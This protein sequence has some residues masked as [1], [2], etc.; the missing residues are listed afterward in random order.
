MQAP[1]FP[2]SPR[3]TWEP[4]RNTPKVSF[5]VPAWNGRQ[6][7]EAFVSAYRALSYP[8]KELVL[9]VGGRDEGFEI[10]K[11]LSSA[12]VLVLEQLPGE[13]KQRA[14]EKSLACSTGEIIYLT[15]IDC[16]PNDDVLHNLLHPVVEGRADVV[17]GASRPLDSQMQVGLVRSHWAV[18]RAT[19][20]ESFEP[21]DGIL[22][23]HAAVR[24]EV[25]ESTRALE[26]PAPSGTDYTLA[27]EL[28]AHGHTV[29]F[30]PGHP[31]PSEYPADLRTYA[32]KQGRWV[33]N[34]LV[35]GARY[36]AEAEV[37]AV[38]RT[39]V[40]PYALLGGLLA[41]LF[42]VRWLGLGA[43]LAALHAVLNRVG[44]QRR[45]RLKVSVRGSLLHL[46]GDQWAALKAGADALR[47][48]STW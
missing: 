7:I 44:L 13:G 38:Q 33:R 41:G 14:L 5:L 19:Q 12:D 25:L 31:I 22:G 40:M 18:E 46:M 27:K 32:H 28:I 48:R 10:A 23:R 20:P 45:A 35:L 17:T 30:V 21:T 6:D 26:V 34:A 9:C 15:D 39:L 36:G 3:L 4:P 1:P 24:R 42:G 8:H 29:Y 43:I 16:R 2:P 11:A 47:R 37:R